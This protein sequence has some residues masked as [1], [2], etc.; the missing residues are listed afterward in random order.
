MWT[1]SQKIIQQLILSL[2]TANIN[3]LEVQTQ[4]CKAG[5][6]HN[7][8]YLFIL[9]FYLNLSVL[10]L[11]YASPALQV[12]KWLEGLTGATEVIEYFW[13]E[14]KQSGCLKRGRVDWLVGLVKLGKRRN[15]LVISK[16]TAK[17]ELMKV[18]KLSLK[19]H[20]K[21]QKNQ[22]YVIGQKNPFWHV[23][24]QQW[25]DHIN[26]NNNLS[27][28]PLVHFSAGYDTFILTLNSFVLQSGVF[29]P[30]ACFQSNMIWTHSLS[31]H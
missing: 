16:P 2:I 4:P 9:G 7:D 31:F 28:T 19:K 20:E 24:L 3:R 11:D 22:T 1:S 5:K 17:W 25:S 18:K 10:N 14:W 23:A 27:S 8:Q 30:P 21:I 26:L 12:S 6:P 29:H 13:M 15:T